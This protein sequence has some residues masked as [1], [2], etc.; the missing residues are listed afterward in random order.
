MKFSTDIAIIGAGVVGLAIAAQVANPSR[1]VYVLEK[2]EKFGLE[3]SSRQSGV[4]H[5]GIYYPQGSLKARL[6]VEGI[7]LLYELCQNNGIG[8]KRLGKLILASSDEEVEQLLELRERGRRNGARDLKMLSKREMQ[9]LEPNI[10]G[11]AALFSPWTSIIDSYSLMQYYIARA[12]DNDAQ[13]AYKTKV[14][15]IERAADGY[16]VTVEES[17]RKGFSFNTGVLINCAGLYCDKIAATAGIDIAEAGY[18]LHYC[19]GEYFSVGGGKSRMVQRLIYP[20]PEHKVTGVG[21]HVT[22]DLEGRMRLGPSVEYVDSID[23]SVDAGHKEIFYNSA[24]KMLPFID[25]EDLEPEMAGIRPKLQGPGEDI[26]DFVIRDESDKG[27]PGFVNL[28]GIESPGLTSSPAIARY[29][30][31]LIEGIE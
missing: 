19:K 11:C 30:A 5:S 27:L 6:C 13:I 7:Q 16:R 15:G 23:Y 28:I 20:V 17:G 10:K 8:Y 25:Y 29:V 1:V 31:R 21:I 4:I 14:V 22:L 9:K 3:T 18:R 2:N 12:K 24:K 26:R